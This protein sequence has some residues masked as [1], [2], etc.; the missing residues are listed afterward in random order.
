MAVA[1]NLLYFIHT[2]YRPPRIRIR[3]CCYIHIYRYIVCSSSS[4][5]GNYV[6]TRSRDASWLASLIHA[7]APRS[8]QVLNSLRSTSI[9]NTQTDAKQIHNMHGQQQRRYVYENNG[10]RNKIGIVRECDAWHRIRMEWRHYYYV[11]DSN[12]NTTWIL[13]YRTVCVECRAERSQPDA[14]VAA[15]VR[16]SS[17]PS[18]QSP[19]KWGNR[20]HQKKKE[21]NYI[22]WRCNC[23]GFNLHENSSNAPHF[24]TPTPN[25]NTPYIH[26]KPIRLSSSRVTHT[27]RLPILFAFRPNRILSLPIFNGVTVELVRFGA[28]SFIYAGQNPFNKTQKPKIQE[29]IHVKLSV[30]KLRGRLWLPLRC[31]S[32]ESLRYV[33]IP[34]SNPSIADFNDSLVY[35]MVIILRFFFLSFFGGGFG[36]ST[37]IKNPLVFAIVLR[38]SFPAVTQSNSH[39]LYVQSG[40]KQACSF[41]EGLYRSTNILLLPKLCAYKINKC[42]HNCLLIFAHGLFYVLRLDCFPIHQLWRYI[43]ENGFAEKYPAW[44]PLLCGIHRSLHDVTTMT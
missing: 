39:E 31:E 8:N 24:P 33:S 23:C 44:I 18:R 38:A 20:F 29:E 9:Y 12:M 34:A 1:R 22:V 15:T 28:K 14:T 32:A 7:T 27:F 5:R 30:E 17:L 10:Q 40:W 37:Q 11:I 25:K 13:E 26:Q 2:R 42:K 4:V 21:K 35:S 16:V 19:K 41:V 6:R 43:F 3:N 36:F